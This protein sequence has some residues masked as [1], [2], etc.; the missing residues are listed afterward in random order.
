MD[1]LLFTNIDVTSAVIAFLLLNTAKNPSFQS[2]LRAEIALQ[3]AQNPGNRKDYLL[4]QDTLLH[5]AAMESVRM[6]PALWFS[7]PERTAQD[8]LIGGFFVP[9]RTAVVID[10]RRL[11]TSAA[12]WGADGEEFR[13]ERFANLSASQYRYGLLRFGMGRGRCLGKNIADMMLKLS[14]LTVVERF[15]VRP[16][17]GEVF[18]RD[19]FTV[20]S[21]SEIEFERI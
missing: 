13:P 18:R 4:K 11:N 2:A 16:R 6:S 21:Q 14:L 7:L 5:F 3:K 15:V 19:T 20:T 17:D 10:W 12:I 9:A 8:K 1:E